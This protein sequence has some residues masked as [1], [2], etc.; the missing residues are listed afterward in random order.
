MPQLVA[1]AA[2]VSLRSSRDEKER[3]SSRDKKVDKGSRVKD[4]KKKRTISSSSSSIRSS[5]GSSGGETSDG[6]LAK[7]VA[8]LQAELAEKNRVIDDLL[9]QLQKS[10]TSAA[11]APAT[12][13]TG[14]AKEKSINLR[15]ISVNEK[16][17]SGGG[18]NA[19]IFSC[20]VDGWQCAMKELYIAQM[21]PDEIK[22]FEQEIQ[23]L[24]SLPFNNNI[25]RYLFHE[26]DA[27]KIRLYITRY[28]CS[29]RDRILERRRD[30]EFNN[31]DGYSVREITKHCLDIAK[32]LSFLHQNAII[33]RD[34]KSD[35]IF[36][37]LNEQK[38]ISELAIGD[39]DTAKKVSTGRHAK[40]LVGTPPYMAPEVLLSNN[41]DAYTFKA[42]VYSL[43]M[44]IYEFLTLK[45]PYEDENQYNLL[46]LKIK[47]TRPRL[48]PDMHP[49]YKPMIDLYERCTHV[50]PDERPDLFT[51]KEELIRWM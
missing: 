9:L 30:I 38:E 41:T 2:T 42:D 21:N 11:S 29:L 34:L 35:N 17:S 10:N 16:L 51:I 20:Y 25:V 6:D 8:A 33:H 32:G 12:P 28:A 3:K 5:G 24:E 1:A 39:F 4:K 23:L 7:K 48:P 37:K 15:N 46:N 43:G 14:R 26:K 44:I 40:T 45:M 13:A 22:N 19:T 49:S 50:N 47:G 27:N 31:G 36:V 18:S